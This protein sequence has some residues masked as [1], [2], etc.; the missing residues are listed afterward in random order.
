MTFHWVNAQGEQVRS[1]SNADANIPNATAINDEVSGAPSSGRDTWDG[2]KW[3]AAAPVAPVKSESEEIID[4][5]ISKGVIA[6]TDL[7]DRSKP[8]KRGPRED[9]SGNR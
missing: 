6:E 5:L 3:V 9:P 4:V 1:T 8:S 2:T 7:S